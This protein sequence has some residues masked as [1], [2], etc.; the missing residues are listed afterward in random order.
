M[1]KQIKIVINKGGKFS[2]EAVGFEN[3]MCKEAT[4]ELVQCLN[5]INVENEEDRDEVPMGDLE[6]FLNV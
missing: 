5:G 3:G 2:V 1:A 6:Q 4:T